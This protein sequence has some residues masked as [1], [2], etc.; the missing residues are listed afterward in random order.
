MPRSSRIECR[1]ACYHVS[2][3][4]ISHL[5]VFETQA[6]TEDFLQ[7]LD[8]VH[9]MFKAQFYAYVLL[10]EGYHLLVRTSLA[11]LSPI[12]RYINSVYAQ[13]YNRLKERK[14]PLFC[15]RY[16]AILINSD[17]YL[18]QV[19]R[20]IHWLPVEHGYCECPRDY[21]WSSCKSYDRTTDAP[22]WLSRHAILGRFGTD[23][24]NKKYMTYV[25]QGIDEEIARFYRQKHVGSVLGS[26]SFKKQL[27]LHSFLPKS[28]IAESTMKI[29]NRL[30]IPE[31]MEHVESQ[32]INGKNPPQ[33][34]HIH[35][36]NIAMVLC[37]E[38]GG[39]S[40]KDIAN[41]FDIGHH[42]SVSVIVSRTK[43]R[44]DTDTRL[45]VYYQLLRDKML[46]KQC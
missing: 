11:N 13:R 4:G 40:L 26:R 14:G 24:P 28:R 23:E 43:K 38:I 3:L 1:D 32:F 36:R 6:D 44:I 10:K 25:D 37:R 31:I 35:S 20:Y 29:I 45:S 42:R 41:A 9:R 27:A 39:Y 5:S 34:D 15:G 19:S 22:N 8:D 33:P 18:V 7:L 17:M 46:L 2:S 30:T 16:K 12:M 21:H